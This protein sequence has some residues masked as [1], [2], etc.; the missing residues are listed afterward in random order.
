MM[1]SKDGNPE[2]LMDEE[3]SKDGQIFYIPRA[4]SSQGNG[5]KRGAILSWALPNNRM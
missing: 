3:G 4:M 2:V 1:I 5:K